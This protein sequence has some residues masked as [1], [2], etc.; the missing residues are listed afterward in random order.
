MFRPNCNAVV[1]ALTFVAAAAGQNPDQGNDIL[2]RKTGEFELRDQNFIEGLKELARRCRF[3]LAIETVQNIH[4][5]KFQRSW[6]DADISA[7][8]DDLVK[9]EPQYSWKMI[10]G[11][12]HVFHR[13][14][15]ADKRNF[16]NVRI[17]K[18]SSYAESSMIDTMFVQYVRKIVRPRKVTSGGASQA[19]VREH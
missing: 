7:I 17:E 16:L 13:E 5:P 8:L 14:L 6:Q 11:V 12:V 9:S 18:F 1:V 2:K 19:R 10:G 4:S 3:P 15:F